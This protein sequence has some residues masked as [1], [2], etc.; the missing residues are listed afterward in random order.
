[1]NLAPSVKFRLGASQNDGKLYPSPSGD[2]QP[3]SN[4]KVPAPRAYFTEIEARSTPGL[5][6]PQRKA[7]P[8]PSNPANR[9]PPGLAAGSPRSRSQIVLTHLGSPVPTRP[10]QFRI[11]GFFGNLRTRNRFDQFSQ[12]H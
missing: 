10:W 12:T 3:S 9:Q 1:M 4:S 11:R 6:S 2:P 7:H 8:A 5:E